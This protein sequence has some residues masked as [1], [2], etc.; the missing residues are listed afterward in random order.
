[1]KKQLCLMIVALAS[2]IGIAAAED[3]DGARP[4]QCEALEGHDCLPNQSS[5]KPLEAK[6]DKELKVGIDVTAKTMKTPY[7]NDLLPIQ[8][9]T[10]NKESLVLQGTSL[11]FAW[12]ATVH[13]TTGRLIFAIAD[14]EGAYVVFGQCKVASAKGQ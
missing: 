1:M 6:K 10:K 12:S 8:R 2:T 9:V 3:F 5:C 14:R 4:M 13:R 11:Q 7:R